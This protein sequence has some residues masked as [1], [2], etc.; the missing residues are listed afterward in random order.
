[1]AI[2]LVAWLEETFAKEL[3]LG[4]SW[5]QEK[6]LNKALGVKLDPDRVWEGL[7]NDNGS[8]LDISNDIPA[9]Y[10]CYLK[11]VQVHSNMSCSSSS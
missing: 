10:K 7:Y 11:I 5:L 2:R 6:N 3:L 1:M 9:E 8:S 4:N